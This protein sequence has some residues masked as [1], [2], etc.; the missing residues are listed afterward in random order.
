MSQSYESHTIVGH[1]GRDP[2]TR[3]LP[4]G[5]AVCNFSLATSR[6]MK[7]Q[8]HTTWWRVSV[9][10]KT[11]EACGAYLK[12]GSLVLAEG[13]LSSDDKGNPR[14]YTASDGTTKASF[15][16]LASSVKFLSAKKSDGE[17]EAEAKEDE[18]IIPF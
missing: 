11:A 7:D 15:E 9:F 8:D 17:Q 10:G 18:P 3:Y 13:V 16:L 5:R 4:D 14:T 1:L 12:K 2:E 6:R